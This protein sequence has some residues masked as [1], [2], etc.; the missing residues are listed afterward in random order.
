MTSE[1]INFAV[2]PIKTIDLSHL[3]LVEIEEYCLMKIHTQSVTKSNQGGFQSSDIDLSEKVLRNLNNH[4]IIETHKLCDE[5]QLKKP[6]KI[7][8]MWVNINN[9]GHSNTNHI[10]P[11][12]LLSGVF[13]PSQSYPENCGEI[14]FRHPAHD[15]MGYDW[16]SQ[17]INYT[18][19]NSLTYKLSPI[20]GHAIIFP[21]W[22]VHKVEPNLNKNFLRVSMSFNMAKMRQK[23]GE[24]MAPDYI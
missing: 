9:Y 22:L 6:T 23:C 8:N 16:D 5:L 2:T 7:D 12:C 17:Q 1:I 13:Y 11:N 15:I 3:N 20:S 10:H 14:K 21:S 18:K 19:Y 24:N 4:L